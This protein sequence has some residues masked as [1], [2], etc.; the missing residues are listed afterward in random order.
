MADSIRTH[1][2]FTQ[3]MLAG[4]LGVSRVS[5]ALAEQGHPHLPYGAGLQM[6]RLV[7][8]TQGLVYNPEGN[9]PAPPALP[10]PAPDLDPLVARLD[11]C[12]HRSRNLRRALERLR[13]QAAP[14]EA[15]LATL[16]ALRTWTG[17][18]RNPSLEESWLALIEHEASSGL[19][20]DCGQGPHKLLEARIA[21]LEREAQVL[22]ELLETPELSS[23][24]GPGES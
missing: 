21:G 23:N 5:V 1:L 10:L 13:A 17:A 20:Y 16:P 2:G 15:R 22:R 14:L 7:L 3:E 18:V 11:Y 4:W 8:A 19:R 6:A 9:T 24:A 12:Q